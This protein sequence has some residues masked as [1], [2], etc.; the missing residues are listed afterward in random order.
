MTGSRSYGDAVAHSL[1][2]GGAPALRTRSL[3][4]GQIGMT[5]ISCGAEHVGMTPR[6]PP[7]D[8]FIAAIYLTDL[9]H[10]ELWSGG[11]PRISQ[12]YAAN[13]MRIVNLVEGYS[14]NIVQPHEALSFYMPRAVLDGFTEDAGRPRIAD[15]RC[16]PGVIDSV[17][18]HLVA[19]LLPAFRHPG[20]AS[21]LFIDQVAQA[22]G[23]HLADHYGGMPSREPKGR[24]APHQLRRAQ[25]LLASRL[26]GALTLA[27]LAKECGLSRGYFLQAFKAAAGCTPHRWLQQHRVATAQAMLRDSAATIA[28]IAIL[29]G[30]VDQSHMTRVFTRLTGSSPAAW[31][32]MAGRLPAR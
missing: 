22:I 32:R 12:G 10:H 1:G 9:R 7:E 3:R 17:V 25:E 16:P 29:C 30:F 6:I 20:Q 2:M 31:R 28:E 14:A 21:A 11:R 26:D 19:A 5:R 18:G 15:L 8:T 13:S 23:T 27:A 24:L 4:H